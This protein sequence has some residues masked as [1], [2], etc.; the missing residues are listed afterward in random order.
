MTDKIEKLVFFFLE[1]DFYESV[2]GSND[3]FLIRFVYNCKYNSGTC[4]TLSYWIKAN[5]FKSF[6]TF[7]VCYFVS[8]YVLTVNR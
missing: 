5:K 1:N 7:V 4:N 3:M 6:K 2:N 8:N